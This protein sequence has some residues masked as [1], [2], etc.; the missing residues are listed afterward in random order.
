GR[1]GRR[2]GRGGMGR[3][4]ERGIVQRWIAGGRGALAFMRPAPRGERKGSKGGEAR[5]PGKKP[6][7]MRLPCNR[8]LDPSHADR[9]AG[10]R[11]RAGLAS[12]MSAALQTPD[13]ALHDPAAVRVGRRAGMQ[14]KRYAS[15]F[16]AQN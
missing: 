7:D 14:R 6:A 1:G 10:R 2:G 8:L 3:R 12:L 15:Y 4:A 5:E 11:A 9:A 13:K 16:P